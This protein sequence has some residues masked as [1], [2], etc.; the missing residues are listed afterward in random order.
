MS[1]ISFFSLVWV[2]EKEKAPGSKTAMT[3]I[4]KRDELICVVTDEK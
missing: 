2:E 4:T 3:A 1:K